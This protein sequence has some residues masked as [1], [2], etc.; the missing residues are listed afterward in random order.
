MVQIKTLT[1]LTKMY[2]SDIKSK[3]LNESIVSIKNS[4]TDALKE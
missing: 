2:V 1:I 4:I 3:E